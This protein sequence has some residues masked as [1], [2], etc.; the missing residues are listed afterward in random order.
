MS[1]PSPP[2][3]PISTTQK[4]CEALLVDE[5]TR[6][7]TRIPLRVAGRYCSTHGREYKELTR[8]YKEVSE[9]VVA[10]KK[11]ACLSRKDGRAIQDVV[12]IESA[13]ADVVTW[14][15]AI[16]EEIAG[17]MVQHRRFFLESKS[18]LLLFGKL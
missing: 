12:G 6:C 16:T 10:L 17:R 1:L 5:E 14:R 9:R 11:R 7:P 13:L 4:L 15:D 2:S 8:A 18:F 3:S